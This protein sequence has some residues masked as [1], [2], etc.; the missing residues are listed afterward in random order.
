MI[1]IENVKKKE[2]KTIITD[3]KIIDHFVF[4]FIKLANQIL[5]YNDILKLKS[6]P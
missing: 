2:T 4:N 1:C 3:N 5:F 6:K